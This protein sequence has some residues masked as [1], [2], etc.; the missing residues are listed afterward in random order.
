MNTGTLFN[1]GLES[2]DQLQQELAALLQ[3]E[4]V[5]LTERLM[6]RVIPEPTEEQ[7]LWLGHRDMGKEPEV[8]CGHE[9]SFVLCFRQ[10]LQRI[11]P[12]GKWRSDVRLTTTVEV[13]T[14]AARIWMAKQNYAKLGRSNAESNLEAICLLRAFMA[15]QACMP[16]H[17]IT[18]ACILNRIC[19]I[20]YR[21]IT[22]ARKFL[23]ANPMI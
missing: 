16:G 8:G 14:T 12:R 3:E 17:T 1:E 6:R 13:P 20:G 7:P 11:G 10:Y 22:S 23:E 9:E 5:A 4:C 2:R 15:S 18:T 21:A 19:T